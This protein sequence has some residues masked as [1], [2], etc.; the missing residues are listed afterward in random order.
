MHAYSHKYYFILQ[1]PCTQTDPDYHV[2]PGAQRTSHGQGR[3]HTAS[4]PG[5]P[6]HTAASLA[7]H[8]YRAVASLAYSTPAEIATYMSIAYP[9]QFPINCMLCGKLIFSPGRYRDHMNM[10]NNIKVHKCP[11]CSKHF[12]FKSDVQRHIRNGVCTKYSLSAW[13]Y[14][15]ERHSMGR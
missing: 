12:T 11:Y 13:A 2:F 15:V 14:L 6:P 9:K 4:G 3:A 5:F 7:S 1:N 8:N 10:H